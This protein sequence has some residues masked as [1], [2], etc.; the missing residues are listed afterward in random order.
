MSVEIVRIEGT[1]HCKVWRAGDGGWVGSCDAPQMTFQANT[2][3]E[4]MDAIQEGVEMALQDF[5]ATGDFEAF[6]QEQGWSV[7]R[8]F[9][10]ETEFDLP[11]VPELV[12]A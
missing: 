6:L 4:M 5:I 12:E 8:P 9:D 10:S 11:F 3:A 7:E 1:I 2:W